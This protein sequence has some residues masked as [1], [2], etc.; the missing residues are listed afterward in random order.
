MN[1]GKLV[2]LLEI[3]IDGQTGMLTNVVVV[4][5]SALAEFDAL[6]VESIKHAAPFDDAPPE[7]RSADGNVYV[8]WGFKRDEV[9]AC[10]TMNVRPFLLSTPASRPSPPS[11]AL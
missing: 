7:I 4:Q 1:D 10:S 8:H 2:T 9:F 5:G 6:A 3:V 11:L